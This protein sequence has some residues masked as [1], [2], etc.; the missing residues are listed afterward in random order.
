[1]KTVEKKGIINTLLAG[2][3]N[4]VDDTTAKQWIVV[5]ES[6]GAPLFPP[7]QYGEGV[8]VESTASAAEKR[9]MKLIGAGVDETVVAERK[10]GLLIGTPGQTFQTEPD[11]VHHHNYT[12][13]AVLTGT[14]ATDRL[15]MYTA[16]ANNINSN[17]KNSVT[18]YTL[19]VADYTLGTDSGTSGTL[20]VGDVV[21]QE[22]SDETAIVAKV[23][24]A[25][26]TMAGDDAAGKIWLY[27]ISDVSAWLETAKTLT[28]SAGGVVTVTNA[29][30]IHGQGLAIIDDA[31][32]FHSSEYRGGISYLFMTRGFVTATTST[33]EKAVT[34]QY[35]VGIGSD[36]VARKP[37]F[38]RPGLDLEYGDRELLFQTDPVSTKTYK[39]FF[40]NIKRKSVNTSNE[41]EVFDVQY[42]VY[43]DESNGTNLTNFASAL[44][45]A[46]AK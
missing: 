21:T 3:A 4:V 24:I 12:A 9:E 25:T 45:T 40:I 6:G 22:T 32:Y 20:S 29:T 42:V 41:N 14:A 2:G 11:V 38:N 39:Q 46:V 17:Y 23:T 26:G 30:T 44:A 43:A 37:I 31:N 36:M 16:L 19:T 5:A 35:A 18:A 15:N 34:G 8:S 1:M 28:S 27:S 33:I 13:P 7:I 10:Y